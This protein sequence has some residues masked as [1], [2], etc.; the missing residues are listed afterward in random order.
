MNALDLILTIII[1]ISAFLTI[2]GL[3][4]PS[5]VIWWSDNNSRVQV[6]KVWGVITV[7]AAILYFIMGATAQDNIKDD[8]PSSMAPTEQV[9]RG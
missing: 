7:I 9:H 4:R 2:I 6:L 8:N 1:V 5:F 3:I